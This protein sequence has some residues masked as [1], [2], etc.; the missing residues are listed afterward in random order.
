MILQLGEEP[1]VG[2]TL[3]ER[4]G[5]DLSTSVSRGL[6]RLSR[7]SEGH[8]WTEWGQKGQRLRPGVQAGTNVGK[9]LNA[10]QEAGLQSA[11][12]WLFTWV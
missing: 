5:G 4:G 8:G 9:A 11:E 3:G 12:R 6:G 2:D 7:R 10:D 1:V